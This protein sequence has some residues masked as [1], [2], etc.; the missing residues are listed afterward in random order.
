MLV[1]PQWAPALRHLRFT[2]MEVVATCRPFILGQ[3]GPPLVVAMRS[4]VSRGKAW[5][6]FF[7]L[8]TPTHSLILVSP[9]GSQ[10]V[11]SLW[12]G[13]GSMV[14]SVSPGC[15][16]TNSSNCELKLFFKNC[17]YMSMCGHFLLS[18]TKKYIN[19]FQSIYIVLGF[20]SHLQVT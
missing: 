14:S 2:E 18:F 4:L 15:K 20:I 13:N 3:L 11:V 10:S 17:A 16:S 6:F 5:G 9:V 1:E 8:L 7:H 12:A 19:C